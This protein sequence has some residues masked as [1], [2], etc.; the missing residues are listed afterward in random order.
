MALFG[1]PRMQR[2]LRYC[3]RP[4]F[5]SERLT[6][7]KPGQRLVFPF[8]NPGPT[9]WTDVLYLTPFEWLDRLAMLMPPPRR[10][11]YHGLLAPMPRCAWR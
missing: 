3:A 9:R 7:V 6:W 1:A 10:H 11:R 2:L 5:A 4:L 8:P